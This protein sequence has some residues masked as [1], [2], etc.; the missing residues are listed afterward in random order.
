MIDFHNNK[1]SMA[2][3]NSYFLGIANGYSYNL[4]VLGSDLSV[5]KPDIEKGPP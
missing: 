2:I 3:D 5:L 1:Q 4:F